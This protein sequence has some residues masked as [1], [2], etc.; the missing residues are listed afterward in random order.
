MRLHIGNAVRIMDTAVFFHGVRCAESVF[1]NE[2]RLFIA[3][4]QG[5]KSNPQSER[6]DLPAPV[7]CLEIRIDDCFKYRISAGMVLDDLRIGRRAAGTVITEADV[8]DR[9]FLQ[10]LQIFFRAVKNNPF[11]LHTLPRP[12]RIGTTRLGIDKEIVV[13]VFFKPFPDI[14]RIAGIRI[15]LT[16]RQHAS[17]HRIRHHLVGHLHG[18][19]ACDKFIV[20]R[21]IFDLGR[22]LAFFKDKTRAHKRQVQQHIDLVECDPVFNQILIV[23]KQHLAVLQVG[24]DHA[25]VFPAA[26]PFDE[27]YRRIKMIDRDQRFDAV[28]P[29]FFKQGTVERDALFI[30]DIIIPIRQDARPGNR[31]TV[32]LEAHL[33]KERNILFVVMVHIDRFMRGINM[34]TVTFQHLH[35]SARHCHAVRSKRNNIHGGKTSSV[36]IIAA[37]ALIC[38]CR[39]APQKILRKCHTY[40][41]AALRCWVSS[42]SA[43]ISMRV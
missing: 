7:A 31:K 38:G 29:A 8:I 26:V 25:S 21:L 19:C 10:C 12:D 4:I 20:R 11:L 16:G 13:P 34:F 27:F 32:Y 9:S 41:S 14:V 43:I 3:V 5:I 33:R 23:F 18:F 24:I 2:Q 30:R 15:V 17:H 28:L 36:R 1:D 22:I 35:L 40:S 42:I 39:T 6:I 37:F